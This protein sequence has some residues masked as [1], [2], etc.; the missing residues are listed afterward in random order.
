[1]P[2]EMGKLEEIIQPEIGVLTHISSAHLENF[3]SKEELICE[4]LK[5]FSKSEKLIFNADKAL[6][7]NIVRAIFPD[8][9]YYTFGKSTENPLRLISLEE[10]P[11]GKAINFEYNRKNYVFQIP[12]HDDASV[13]NSL[14]VLTDI[15]ALGEDLEK[16]L[17]KTR[18]LLTIEMRKEIKEDIRDSIII[19]DILN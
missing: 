13:E 10:I 1:K 12:F 6:V 16:Y 19:N 18:N 8:K 9:N 4:K 3:T 7:Q 5:L 14:T 2:A 17:P 11:T 15:A